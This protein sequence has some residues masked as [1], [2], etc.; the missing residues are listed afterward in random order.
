MGDADDGPSREIKVLRR[1]G[2]GGGGGGGIVGKI[3]KT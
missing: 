1:N 2:M 3:K